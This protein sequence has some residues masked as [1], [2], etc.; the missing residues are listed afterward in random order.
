MGVLGFSMTET[1]TER[2]DL[3]TAKKGKI[4]SIFRRKKTA[5]LGVD[6]SSASIKILE[7][8]RNGNG[9]HVESYAVE[10]L[11]PHSV[12]EKTITDADLVGEA[13]GRAVRKSGTKILCRIRLRGHH[14]G[15]PHAGQPLRR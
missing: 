11:P 8:A 1:S 5:L 10:P 3:V 4:V 9:Y 2:L 14:Q 6:I 13:I 7:L 15:D 12:V